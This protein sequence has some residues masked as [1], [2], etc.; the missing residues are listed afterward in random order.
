MLKILATICALASFCGCATTRQSRD[1][2]KFIK[3]K[4]SCEEKG[5]SVIA[6]A[7]TEYSY[8]C[9]C[10]DYVRNDAI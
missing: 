4:N 3:C 9:I 5:T 7:E 8:L 2:A 6:L 1:S 10:D